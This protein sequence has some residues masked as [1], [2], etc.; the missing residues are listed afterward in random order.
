MFVVWVA[1]R[2]PESLRRWRVAHRLRHPERNFRPCMRMKTQSTDPY[3]LALAAARRSHFSGTKKNGPESE[4]SQVGLQ[5]VRVILIM[6]CLR[7]AIKKLLAHEQPRSRP[8]CV[9]L[10]PSTIPAEGM[11]VTG[12]EPAPATLTGCTRNRCSNEG[13]FP[14][15]EC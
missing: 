10:F 5:P 4:P 7:S 2:I 3:L 9:A 14:N 13:S 11:D 1:G 8:R 12:F 15:C 6:T